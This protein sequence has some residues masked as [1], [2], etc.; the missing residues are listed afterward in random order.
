MQNNTSASGFFDDLNNQDVKHLIIQINEKFTQFDLSDAK[1]QNITEN[2][3]AI[4][5]KIELLCEK[6]SIL[7]KETA[8]LFYDEVNEIYEKLSHY[9]A[10][11]T[12][13]KEEIKKAIEG[14]N[15]SFNATKA[16]KRIYE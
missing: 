9:K 10:L 7:P 3:S 14:I 16:Y 4:Y 2:V 11:M 8:K 1:M 13:E 5:N 6:I 12:T 15:N